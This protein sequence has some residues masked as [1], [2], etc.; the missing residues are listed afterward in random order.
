VSDDRLQNIIDTVDN[1]SIRHEHG[2]LL[3]DRDID[4]V[5]DDIGTLFD[6]NAKNVFGTKSS[7]SHDDSNVRPKQTSW[8]N[9]KCRTSR[10]AFHEA[11]KRLRTTFSISVSVILQLSILF[12]ISNPNCIL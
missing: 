11:R 7:L 8:F 12:E 3:S 2:E 9:N 10:K 5:I 6:D 4:S 1:I